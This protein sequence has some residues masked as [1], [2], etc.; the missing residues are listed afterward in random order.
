MMVRYS[1]II[2]CMV[3]LGIVGYVT[4]AM[5]RIAGDCWAQS[6]RLRLRSCSRAA[7]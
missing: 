1:T 6:R 5:V 7:G 4:S 2:I 3:T